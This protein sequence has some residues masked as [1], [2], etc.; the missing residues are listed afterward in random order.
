M[1]SFHVTVHMGLQK[2]A[3]F[4]RVLATVAPANSFTVMP[5]PL[6]EM[7]GVVPQWHDM[8]QVDGGTLKRF[9]MAEVRIR[10]DDR[11]RTTI[12]AFG[13]PESQPLLGKY[14]LDGF[15]LEVD[16]EGERLVPVRLLLQ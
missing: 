9:F 10:F 7:L 1:A 8:I 4:Q 16:E 12:C 2:D 3:R 15:G 13:D 5:S 14:T 6:L 11:E